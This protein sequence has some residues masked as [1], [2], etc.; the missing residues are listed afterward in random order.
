[1]IKAADCPRAHIV[2][3]AARFRFAKNA[4]GAKLMKNFAKHWRFLRAAAGTIC[5]LGQ[6][7]ALII[8]FRDKNRENLEKEG[9]KYRREKGFAG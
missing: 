8:D 4:A 7:A 5:A 6:S 3:L 1:M 9:V 2:P